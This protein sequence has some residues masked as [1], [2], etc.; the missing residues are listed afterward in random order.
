M[1]VAVISGYAHEMQVKREIVE[2]VIRP[3]EAPRD[4]AAEYPGSTPAERMGLVWYLT[5]Q[6]LAWSHPNDGEFRLQ[7]SVERIQRRGR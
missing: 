6:A 1:A 7:R 4:E 3:G 2:R 5:R